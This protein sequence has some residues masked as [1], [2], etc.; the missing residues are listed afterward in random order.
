VKCRRGLL[1]ALAV[2]G[3]ATQSLAA[4][5]VSLSG[6]ALGLGTRVGESRGAPA[7][8]SSLQRLR[9]MATW[10]GPR[11]RLDGAYEHTITLRESG[12][13]GAQ[14]FTA[15]GGATN[16]DWL[17][18]GG[19]IEERESVVWRHR[20]DRAALSVEVTD[21]A[22]L[23]VGR[24]PVSWA[25]TLL[26]TPAD[27][28]SPFDPSDPFREYRQGV[29]AA[30]IRIY[31]GAA[32][33]ID[34]VVRRS[35]FGF[36]QTTTAALRG[37]T[38]V[39][40]W[41][42]S[43]WAGT[44]HGDGAGAVAISGSLGNWA[45]RAEGVVRDSDD[46][47]AVLRST[48]GVDRNYLVSRRDLYVIVE[49]LHDGFGAADGSEVLELLGTGIAR[50]GELQTHGRDE[51]ALQL[52]YQLHPLASLTGLVLVNLHDGSA[53]FAP[54]AAYSASAGVSIQ[55]GSYV[56]TGLEGVDVSGAPRSEYGQ[57]PP[58][59]YLSLSWFF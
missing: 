48:I 58:V 21:Q 27:P 36:E 56:S 20:V 33:E 41:D 43:A 8:Y 45:V 14:F 19:A 49:Y 10:L 35:D 24:Q 47:G 5:P 50:R 52:S 40:G 22:E 39:R 46:A 31:P 3:S 16:G 57:L 30:R 9:G 28:F 25:T 55:A 59:L 34:L 42:V 11:L 54:G 2:V 18:L 15:S 12:V 7:G 53:L 38:S 44:V 4:Q 51:A 23:I 6:Y 26:F 1:T 29:D 17:D 37:S 32:S 13:A